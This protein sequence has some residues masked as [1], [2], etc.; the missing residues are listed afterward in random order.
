MS[1]KPPH[2][3][4][5]RLSAAD[6]T[7]GAHTNPIGSWACGHHRELRNDIETD[8]EGTGRAETDPLSEALVELH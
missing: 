4:L 6:E 1:P 8:H 3:P 7:R 5:S 2:R